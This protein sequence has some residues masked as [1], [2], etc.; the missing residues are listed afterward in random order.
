MITSS[1]PAAGTNAARRSAISLGLAFLAAALAGCGG[2]GGGGD[3][4][5]SGPLPTG[6]SVNAQGPAPSTSTFAAEPA[7]RVSPASAG[8]QSL[9][10]VG[11]VAN[12]GHGV[13]WLSGAGGDASVQLRRFDAQ[14]LP[15]GPHILVGVDTL[16]GTPAA[17]VLP[18]GGMVVA[19]ALAGPASVDQPWVT[20]SAIR[21]QHLDA[22]GRMGTD[23]D[24]GEVLQN[25]IGAATMR[26]VADPAVVQWEDGSFLVGW[27]A[28]EEDANGPR[29][30]FWVQRF[31]AGGQPVGAA[32]MAAP[33]Q[34]DS[35]FRLTAAPGGGWVLTT[36]V[37]ALGQNLLRHHAFD[38]AVAPALA[39]GATGL[40]EGT[41]LVPLHGGGAAM[42]SPAKVHGSVQLYGRDGQ[43][44]GPATALPA[45]PVAATA[46]LDGGFVAFHAG[47]AGLVAQRFD[48][49]GQPLGQPTNVDA[50][51]D[52]QGAPLAG[53]GLVIG[54]TAAGAGGT[55]D[56]MA[57]RLR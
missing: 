43:P 34:L 47:A 30:Q 4:S 45:L 28:V 12:G 37:R 25:R 51:G 36:F 26:Y 11:A 49:T 44:A 27:A 13:A 52:L 29:P 38:G 50:A 39:A 16:Q 35:G 9:L 46:L 18:D 41:L 48:A 3:L 2:G 54:W 6:T 5:G 33:G 8:Q 23:V 24:V 40:A 1:T 56:V 21:V 42:L 7:V 19:T 55:S 20:R 31:D 14:G 53:G 57:Q 10:A 17:A 32:A 22:S 15:A